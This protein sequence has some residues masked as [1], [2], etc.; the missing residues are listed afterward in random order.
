MVK[1]NSIITKY[2]IPKYTDT[3]PNIKKLNK[4]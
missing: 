2:S 1:Y 3:A 4:V